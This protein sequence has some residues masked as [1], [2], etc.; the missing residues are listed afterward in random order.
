M[1]SRPRLAAV[2]AAAATLALLL[3]AASLLGARGG[4]G[5]GAATGAAVFGASEV[6]QLLTGIPQEGSVLGEPDAPVT[7]VEYADLQC[8]FC[9]QWAVGTFRELVSDYVRAGQ[10]RIE[11]RG[12][13][14]IGPDSERA[15]RA[16][17][18]A[19]EQNRLWHALELLYMNQGAENAGWVSDDLLDGIG[20]SVPGLDG[21]RMLSA[22]G[23]DSVTEAMARSAEQARAAG[24]QGTPSF[25]MGPTG[26]TLA[27]L[28][29]TSLDAAEFRAAIGALLAG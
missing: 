18:A 10:L 17:L 22:T 1:L 25:E 19:G 29:I 15:L 3:V 11:F 8:P 24:V 23:S 21:E 2:A 13:A 9:A 27:P 28:E 14:F 16:A 12:M 20:R 5:G 6:E 7:L 4:D 26:G